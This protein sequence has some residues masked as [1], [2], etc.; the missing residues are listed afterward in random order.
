M[1]GLRER[2]DA[3]GG[4]VKAGRQADGTFMVEARIPYALAAP[5]QTEFTS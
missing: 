1:I 4:R 5:A 3:I 2:V